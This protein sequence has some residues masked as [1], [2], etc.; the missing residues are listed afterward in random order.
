MGSPT[1]IRIKNRAMNGDKKIRL[2]TLAVCEEFFKAKSQNTKVI[3]ISNTP[4]YADPSKA[5]RVGND[6]FEKSTRYNV[7]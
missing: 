4:I 6:I 2:L 7:M 1:K 3:P 5:G